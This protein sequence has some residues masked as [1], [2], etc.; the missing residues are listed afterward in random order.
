MMSGQETQTGR[1]AFS[2]DSPFLALAGAVLQVLSFLQSFPT[3]S[4]KVEK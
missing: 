3:V 1:L 4:L 2:P